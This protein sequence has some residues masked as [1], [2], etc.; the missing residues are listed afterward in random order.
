VAHGI[1]IH[2]GDVFAGSVGSPDRL[3]Y[4]MVGD[5]VN[6]A[7]RIQN[8]NKR[9]GTDILVSRKTRDG[10]KD[11]DV[12][13]ESLGMAELRGKRDGVEIFRLL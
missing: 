6:V 12:R 1:G 11:L 5:A 7:S 10:L 3:V 9:F 13:F 8:L 2:T 4:A